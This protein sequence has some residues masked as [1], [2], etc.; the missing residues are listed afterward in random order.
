MSLHTNQSFHF[1]VIQVNLEMYM[2]ILEDQEPKV[3]VENPVSQ[4][5]NSIN[6]ILAI[7]TVYNT[8]R[9]TTCLCVCVLFTIFQLSFHLVCF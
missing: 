3:N 1:F 5:S 8:N 9:H 7:I 2:L 4:V 6:I